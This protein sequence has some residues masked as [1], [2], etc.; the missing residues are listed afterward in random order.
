MKHSNDRAILKCVRNYL[1]RRK[2]IEYSRKSWKQRKIKNK[3][4]LKR[5]N[6]YYTLVSYVKCTKRNECC[7]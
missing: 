2:V 6:N 1:K 3:D 5:K 7:S 4:V